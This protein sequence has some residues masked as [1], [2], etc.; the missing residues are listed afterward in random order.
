MLSSQVMTILTKWIFSH[1]SEVVKQKNERLSQC[2]TMLIHSRVPFTYFQQCPDILPTFKWNKAV[3]FR[4]NLVIPGFVD[5]WKV[6]K[7]PVGHQM[8]QRDKGRCVRRAKMVTFTSWSDEMPVI[9]T[10]FCRAFRFL[11]SGW[12]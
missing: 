8:L 4:L 12:Y 2:P 5:L 11:R 7:A 10:K 6:T 9:V 3:H 1:I